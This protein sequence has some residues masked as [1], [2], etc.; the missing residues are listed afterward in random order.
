MSICDTVSC[1]LDDTCLCYTHFVA[2]DSFLKPFLYFKKV[3]GSTWYLLSIERQDECWKKACT[4][5]YPHCQYHYLD[6]Q[7]LSDPNRNA[8]L[9]SSNLSGL[10]DQNSHFFQFGIFD[11]AMTLEITSSNFLTKYYYCLWWGLRN[12]R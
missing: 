10:C 8:W 9:K 1:N 2:S 11:D 5:Q 3:L 7:S 6:C 4:L 12:L